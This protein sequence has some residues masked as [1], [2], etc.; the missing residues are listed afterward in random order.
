ME[1]IH[2][3]GLTICHVSLTQR[4]MCFNDEGLVLFRINICEK[5][6]DRFIFLPILKDIESSQIHT[7]KSRLIGESNDETKKLCSSDHK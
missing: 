2:N 3:C 4:K 7:N 6:L 1:K 5:Y